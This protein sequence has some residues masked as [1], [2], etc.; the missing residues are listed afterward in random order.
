MCAGVLALGTRAH[1]AD[2]F[3]VV[4]GRLESRSD[5]VVAAQ[6]GATVRLAKGA[7]LRLEPGTKLYRVHKQ[8]PLW[9]SNRGRTLTHLLALASGRIDVESND[10]DLAVM[11]SAPLAVTSF[12]RGGRMHIAAEADQVSIV[13][14]DGS[15]SWAVKSWKFTPLAAGKVHNIAKGSEAESAILPAPVVR[16]ENNLFGGF[17]PRG[18]ALSGVSWE[19]V[20][21]AVRYRVSVEQLEP[22]RR[23]VSNVETTSAALSSPPRLDPG[24]YA[25]S[26]QAVDRF[27]IN[28]QFSSSEPFTVMGVR[29]SDGGYV[30]AQGNIIAGYDRS[31]H[32]TYADG[33]LMKG[34]HEWGPLPDEI[35]LPSG[36]PMNLHLRQAG[37]TRLVSA[38]LLPPRV[39]T[40]VFVGPKFARWPGDSLRVEVRISAGEPRA[41][42]E[43]AAPGAPPAWITP[44]FRVQLGIDDLPVTWTQNGDTYVTEIPPQG[45]EGPWIVRVEVED[46]YGHLLGRDFVEVAR[47]PAPAPAAAKAPP[48]GPTQASR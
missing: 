39:T 41:P 30:D 28:G 45:G 9:L 12:V 16:L 40:S 1:A 21:G 2:E 14:L 23:R 11:V 7:S 44:R 36:E 20:P 34:Q 26:V 15:V 29:S 8:T 31:V 43:G 46:Q 27:G 17:D 24:R 33:L 3:Q 13:N 47:R 4:A 22:E 35:V 38:R 19:P 5:G 18:A 42:S 37:D 6:G 48:S 25:L 32:L 10:P